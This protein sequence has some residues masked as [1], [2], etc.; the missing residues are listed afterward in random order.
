MDHHVAALPGWRSLNPLDRKSLLVEQLLALKD[1]T[2]ERSAT[3]REVL[4]C[5]GLLQH[6][7]RSNRKAAASLVERGANILLNNDAANSITL[8]ENRHVSPHRS[9]H[10]IAT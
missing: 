8:F 1:I 4:A 9:E 7:S 10:S 5:L 6:I 3:P 2:N